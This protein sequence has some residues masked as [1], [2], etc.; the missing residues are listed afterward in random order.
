MNLPDA[1]SPTLLF[2]DNRGTVDWAKGTSTKGMRHLNQ[3]S[4]CVRE[5][6]QDKEIALHHINGLVN[7]SDI[8][9]KEMRDTAHFC[10][11]RDSFMMSEDRFNTFVSASSAWLDAS[12]T[13][14]IALGY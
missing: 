14:G 5:S 8:F 12:W 3:R 7:P 4:V 13:G 9:T 6:I 2:N 11:L 1:S 10:E